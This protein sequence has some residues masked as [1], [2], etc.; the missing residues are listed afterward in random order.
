[1]EKHG[2]CNHTTVSR[3]AQLGAQ[4]MANPE[5]K[6]VADHHSQ[7]QW[8]PCLTKTLAD[9]TDSRFKLHLQSEEGVSQSIVGEE[10]TS[11][12]LDP[13]KV[14]DQHRKTMPFG[15]CPYQLGETVS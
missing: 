15:E 4:K 11:F 9:H 8:L 6:A 5:I 13:T 10:H 12:P 1:M 14:P 3:D 2:H 7:S